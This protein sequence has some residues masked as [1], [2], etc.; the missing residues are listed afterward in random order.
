[1]TAAPPKMMHGAQDPADHRTLGARKLISLGEG[2][3]VPELEG[4]EEAVLCPSLKEY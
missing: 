1:M 2:S 3:R 4:E